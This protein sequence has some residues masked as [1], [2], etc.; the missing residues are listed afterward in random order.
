MLALAR[1]SIQ[2]GLR[3]GKPLALDLTEY[4]SELTKPCATFVTLHLHGNLRGCI[5]MLE[6][7][8]PLAQDIADNAF[9]AAF[10]DSRFNPLETSE[11]D[12]LE[13]H[14]SLLSPPEPMQF[15]TEQDLLAQ[16]QPG[17]DGII[18]KEGHRRA[19]FLPSVWESLP[20]KT[21]FLNHLKIKAGLRS[22]Y[23][24][25]SIQCDRYYAQSI[26]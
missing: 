26:P 22:D 3:T 11:F 24:S 2:S 5:G 16:L 21:D 4:P 18:L 17:V 12:G 25:D 9:A 13:I 10:K 6:A 1:K 20:N 15:K 14:L 8:K 23:W 7:K 19:T